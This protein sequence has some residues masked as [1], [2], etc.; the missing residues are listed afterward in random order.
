M[1]TINR[2]AVI[3]RPLKPFMEWVNSAPVRGT[4]DLVPLDALQE[5]ATVILT[6][7]MDT[8]DE[9]LGWL[10]SFKSKLFE[11][12]LE[13]WCTDRS[14]WPEKRTARLFDQWFDLEVHSM[15]FDAVGEPIL[16]SLQETQMNN[17]I[18]PGDSVRVRSGVIEPECAT[19]LSGW[20]GRVKQMAADPDSGAL[21]AWVEW[22]SQTLRGL[23]PGMIRRCMEADVSWDGQALEARDLLPCEERDSLAQT[24]QARTDLLA[25]YVWTDLDEQGKRI[26]QILRD[27]FKANP[28]F[29][30]MDAWEDYL[31]GKLHFP[32][33]ARVVVEQDSG[34]LKMEM[35]VEVRELSGIDP[36]HGLFVLVQRGGRTFIFP[37]SDLAVDDP[38]SPNFLPLE[39]YGMWFENK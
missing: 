14:T 9:A 38:A 8:N 18:Q 25:R 35:E 29:T 31:K 16:T 28:Q 30:C 6:P 5:D 11:T 10:K 15:V 1:Q 32:F 39:D 26:Y 3:I 22:D 19:D 17:N 12:E 20:E 34:P 2:F 7:E 33:L 36:E 21:V 37:L 4:D 23:T 13:S 27:T 24:D